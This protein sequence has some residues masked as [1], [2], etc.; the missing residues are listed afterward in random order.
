MNRAILG[1]VAIAGAVQLIALPAQAET[2]ID[3][4]KALK[5]ELT[6]GKAV[7][8]Q[9]TATMTFTPALVTT[10]SLEGT[11]GFDQRGAAA[12]DL[13]QTV[14]YSKDL[15]RSMTKLDRAETEALQE[16]PVQ[17]IS[18]RTASY[19]AGPVVG[20]AL[21]T[22]GASWVRY[23]NTELPPSNLIL[24]VLE[25]DTLKTLLAK[26]ASVRDGV[27]KGS[28]RTS[29]LAA[30]SPAFASRFGAHSKKG[31]DGKVSYT[32]WLGPTGL[33]ERV[34]AKAVIPFYD[35][36]VQVESSTRFGD[37]GRQA[38]VLLPLEGDVIDQGQVKDSVP[39]DV[40]G[41]WN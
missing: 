17:M 34:S 32:L 40:P 4:V 38:T 31:R 41:I 33:V 14:R 15:L 30:V 25:P 2:K 11:I 9:A 27:V 6:R 29:K 39:K 3:P 24:E 1:A 28:I 19:V 18:S 13:A 8:V 20:R 37:W 21:Q 16:G 22:Q 35:V 10:S 5:A 7:N 26:P 12:S 36:S 23:R